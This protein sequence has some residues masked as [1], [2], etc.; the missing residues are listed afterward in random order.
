MVTATED[1]WQGL[2]LPGA[3][4]VIN[5]R[6]VDASH[7]WNFFWAR[8]HDGRYLLVL[9]YS[10]GS[11]PA[12]RLPRL[13]GIEVREH[14]V[15]PDKPAVLTFALLDPAQRDIFYHLCTDIIKRA[16]LAASEHEAVSVAL[17]RTWRWHYL[18]SGGRDGRLSTEAQQGLIGELL[19]LERFLLP[20]LSAADA[21]G[22]WRGPLG[23]PK[24]FEV[25]SICIEA[26]TCRGASA[27]FVSITSEHQLDTTGINALFMIVAQLTRA[28]SDTQGGVS[29]TNVAHRIR[30]AIEAGDPSAIDAYDGLLEAAGFR[31]EDDYADSL[32][33]IGDSRL[34]HVDEGFPRI[35]STAVPT[36]VGNVTYT[37]LLTECERFQVTADVLVHILGKQG[38]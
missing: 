16:S 18:L 23:S 8:N 3:D 30:Q 28:P 26:K 35:T 24:D 33:L 22:A 38:L 17:A 2:E 25:G 31:W 13:K 36:G 21:V 29:I 9:R 10:P 1:P 7:P 20:C 5:A 14:V 37:I 27:P 11:S 19:V 4:Q 6:R 12:G 32:W 15:E 34:I